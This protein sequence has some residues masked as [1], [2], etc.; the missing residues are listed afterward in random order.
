ME[1]TLLD[2]EPAF[3]PHLRC[4]GVSVE[5]VWVP[6]CPD[7]ASN[8]RDDV[9]AVPTNIGVTSSSPKLSCQLWMR[10][11][12]LL[13]A[14]KEKVNN[15][16]LPQSGFGAQKARGRVGTRKGEEK[17]RRRLH[18][19]KRQTTTTQ[20]GHW[21]SRRRAS[22][23][24]AQPNHQMGEDKRDKSSVMKKEDKKSSARRR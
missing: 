10:R 22:S 19:T 2:R 8:D 7:S 9:A 17:S 24:K 6:C 20:E 3:V 18:W 16:A 23:E 12:R 14:A 4:K 11:R 15:I 5:S 21:T 1:H 13:R